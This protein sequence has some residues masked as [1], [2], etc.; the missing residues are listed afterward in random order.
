MS[1]S[2]SKDLSYQVFTVYKANKINYR[3]SA[4][5]LPSIVLSTRLFYPGYLPS[6][7]VCYWGVHALFHDCRPPW[8]P[9]E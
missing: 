1:L 2:G 8:P 9:L 5:E 6:P 4:S 3:L 7:L